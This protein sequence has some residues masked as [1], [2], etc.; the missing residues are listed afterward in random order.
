MK[1]VQVWEQ[2]ELINTENHILLKQFPIIATLEDLTE[3]NE[4]HISLGFIK[5][6]E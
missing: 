5:G 3:L 1:V 2:S 6:S 4:I